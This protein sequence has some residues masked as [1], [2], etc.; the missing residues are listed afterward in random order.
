MFNLTRMFRHRNIDIWSILTL[1]MRWS[2]TTRAR[3]S[4][5]RPFSDYP[6]DGHYATEELEYTGP[7]IFQ[8]D[9]NNELMIGF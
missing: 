6:P 9:A 3:Q 5:G 2:P 8:V 4:Y 7:S 1:E